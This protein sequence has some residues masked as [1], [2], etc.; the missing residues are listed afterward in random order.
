[1]DSRRGKPLTPEAK[2]LAVSVKHYFDQTEIEPNEPSVNRAAD[3]LGIGVAT[4]KRI[5][6]DYNR[7]PSL[8][9]EPAKKR[10]RPVYAVSIS[11]QEA[12]RTY[13]RTANIEGRHITLADVQEFLKEN[14][15]DDSFHKACDGLTSHLLSAVSRRQIPHTG[16][17]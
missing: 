6:A 17:F 11:H 16:V 1:M 9:E 10:G 5:M 8:L 13:I 15:G 3:A 7:D 4:V 12:V 2:K 14:Y